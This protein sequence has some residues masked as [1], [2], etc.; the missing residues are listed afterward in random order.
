MN[1][2]HPAPLDRRALAQLIDATVLADVVAQLRKDLGEAGLTEPPADHG[3][4]ESVRASV[5]EVLEALSA[6]GAHALGAVLYRVDLP[7]H[8]A[9]AAMDR[10]GLRELAGQLVLRTLQKVLT[11]RHYRPPA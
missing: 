6:L 3:A 4:F 2:R 5:L 9:R 7:E 1:E 11:R 8:H 10:G